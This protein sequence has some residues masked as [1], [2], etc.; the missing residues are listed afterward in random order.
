MGKQEQMS[1]DYQGLAAQPTSKKVGFFSAILIVM[2][3][4]IG[5]GIFF[6]A[7]GVLA[8]SQGNL[9]FA[10]FA[11]LIAAFAVIT[12][13][14]A[15]L[16]VASARNDNLSLIG[17]CKTFNSRTIYKASKNFMFYI[18]LPLTYFFMP[19]YVI[20][21]LQDAIQGFGGSASILGKSA[22]GADW[23]IWF[24]I[25]LGMA[26]FFMFVSGM[27]SKAG[28][29]MN[30]LFLG[31]KFIP[32][33]I[34]PILGFTIAGIDG[35][36]VTAGL[37][38]SAENT[39][40][41]GV[42][43][44]MTSFGSMSPF[45]GI[46][47]AIGAIFFAYDGFYVTAGIQSE[48]K[49]PKKTPLAI[50]IGLGATTVV[51]LLIAISMSLTGNGGL[52]GLKE[53]LVKRN[54]GWLFGLINL[55]VAFGV[56]GIINGFAMWAPRFIEDLISENELPFSSKYKNR[57]NAN[58]PMVGIYYSLALS[59]PTIILF[60]L[61]GAYGYQSIG[62]SVYKDDYGS[63]EM[64]GIYGFCDLMGTWS[65]VLA[66]AFI[67]LPIFGCIQNRKTNRVATEQNKHLVWAGWSSVA[68]FAVALFV[69]FLDPIINVFILTAT[70]AGET[71][72]GIKVDSINMISRAMKVVVLV[73]FIFVT[74]GPTIIEDKLHIKK[75]G[76]IENYEKAF[77]IEPC[78]RSY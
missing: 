25:A 16:E 69:T 55:A 21:S 47:I 10:I 68:I 77:N 40:I 42:E 35:A 49:E 32:L 62:H 44:D 36:K 1:A 38:G 45:I 29:T 48:M 30:K 54:V 72:G 26:L 31:I 23:V 24:F 41:T 17:W 22:S 74:F 63:I 50:L 78:V 14:L 6:K 27:S 15:L 11:W 65:A 39:G 58:K 34:V 9:I 57:L 28:N 43:P 73:L 13:A 4:S 19:L 20:M 70:I 3:S 66:F 53:F 59:V 18:Y 75:Y 8:S 46:F 2:G 52:F 7:Q 5:A 60:T 67:C 71:H 33:I 61:I 37:A 12:M 51:Y 76:S 64:A 56:M